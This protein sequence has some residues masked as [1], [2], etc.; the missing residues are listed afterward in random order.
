MFVYK[1]GMIDI[2]H[3]QAR[4]RVL[5]ENLSNDQSYLKQERYMSHEMHDGHTIT[6]YARRD[7]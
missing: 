5:N 7:S 1:L 3:G 4:G 2:Y 6:S